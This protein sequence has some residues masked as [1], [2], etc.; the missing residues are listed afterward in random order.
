MGVPI[1]KQNSYTPMPLHQRRENLVK[2]PVY[3]LNGHRRDLQYIMS[4]HL[5]KY[6][7]QKNEEKYEFK[8]IIYPYPYP[9]HSGLGVD[10]AHSVFE[11]YNGVPRGRGRWA[12]ALYHTLVYNRLSYTKQPNVLRA[13]SKATTGYFK[14]TRTSCPESRSH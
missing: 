4:L 8:G 13:Y 1:N 2:S 9:K 14:S 5:A 3:N 10:K 6:F 7:T 11:K 12:E